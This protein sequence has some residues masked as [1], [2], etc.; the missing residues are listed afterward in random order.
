[1]IIDKL[2]KNVQFVS[3]SDNGQADNGVVTWTIKDVE[4]GKTGK[5]T[6]KVKV[7]TGARTAGKVVN[8]A[9]VQVGNDQSF[10]TEE[11]I[12]PVTMVANDS[13]SPKTGD[14]FKTGLWV[15][16]L[17]VALLGGGWFGVKAFRGKKTGKEKPKS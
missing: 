5:V 17:V 9:T 7:L 1:M 11:V 13:T 12:N 14:D 6:L 16:L 15:T 3:A 4:A 10:E 2:D 8:K